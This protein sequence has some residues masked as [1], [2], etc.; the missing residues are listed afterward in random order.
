MRRRIPSFLPR[1]AGL[2]L[3]AALGAGLALGGAAVL[4]KLGT[5]NATITRPV[6]AGGNAAL[7]SGKH[8][9]IEEIYEAAGP[10]VVQITSTRVVQVPSDPFFGVPF[11][12]QTQQ[13][14]ALGSGFVIDKTG[15]IITNY[16]VVAGA[17]TVQVS[18]SNSESL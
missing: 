1:A 17:R 5:R 11:G 9:T 18:F 3:V 4:G 8:R 10:G 15:H 16:H 6:V 14:Q 2:I 7:S 12:R 13:E